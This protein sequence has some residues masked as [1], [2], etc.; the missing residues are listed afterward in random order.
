M[1][2]CSFK[3]ELVT[4]PI[5]MFHCPECG[6]M[7]LAGHAHIG[8]WTTEDDVLFQ[9]YLERPNNE[10]ADVSTGLQ[11]RAPSAAGCEDDF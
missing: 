4:E 11:S 3:P 1:T 10:I 2:Q 6:E 5:G 8:P 7:Q 9:E